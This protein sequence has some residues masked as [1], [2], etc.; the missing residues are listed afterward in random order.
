MTLTSDSPASVVSSR[1]LSLALGQGGGGTTALA[2]TISGGK[3]TITTDGTHDFGV[4][5]VNVKPRHV[6]I[7]S[8]GEAPSN[9]G[10]NTLWGNG[11]T[12][13]DNGA[14]TTAKVGPGQ[15]QS[16]LFDHS[17]SS[18]AALAPVTHGA[19]RK[20]LVHRR[21]FEDFDVVT[22]TAIRTRIDMPLISGSLPSPGDVVTGQ[23]SGATGVVQ[24]ADPGTGG[25]G[26]I[27]Y[28]ASGGSVNDPEPTIFQYGEVMQWEGGSAT[29]G[30]GSEEYQTGTFFTFNNKTIRF[31]PLDR[32]PQYCNIYCGDGKPGY[33]PSRPQV[34][35]ES[36]AGDTGG[37]SNPTYS[38]LDFSYEWNTE[39]F[40]LTES[41]APDAID[42]SM[43]WQKNAVVIADG[44]VNFATRTASLPEPKET[45]YQSQVSNGA[46]AGSDVYYDYL[47][48]DDSHYFVMLRDSASGRFILL[49][50]SAWSSTNIEAE[51]LSALLPA[52]THIDIYK[53]GALEGSIAR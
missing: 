6:W 29:N 43:F 4:K 51:N 12:T 7:A 41:S 19:Q 37:I 11:L 9:L 34:V 27:F 30:E 26:A 49:P 1:A 8:E 36:G 24:S 45:V 44:T 50:P 21:R 23:T 39:L 52:W 35:V 18:G 15:T 10:V 5:P 17:S 47:Y 33:T 38:Q 13:V 20:K 3:I 2:Y 48:V 46:Q 14:L 22:A 32:S 53:D 42:G 25:K 16:L 28:A 31:Y 40:M